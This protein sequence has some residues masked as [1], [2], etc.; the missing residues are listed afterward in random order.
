MFRASLFTG[1]AFFYFRKSSLAC[2]CTR[3]D[4]DAIFLLYIFLSLLSLLYF[5][6]MIFCRNAILLR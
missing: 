1:E 6:A 2:V 4:D 5:V 3:G